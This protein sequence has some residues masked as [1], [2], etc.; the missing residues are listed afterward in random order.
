MLWVFHTMKVN[1]V[2]YLI[3]DCRQ[4]YNTDVFAVLIFEE[5][6]R[7]LFDLNACS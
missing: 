7:I 3:S 4:N 5:L 2:W 1:Y 6:C